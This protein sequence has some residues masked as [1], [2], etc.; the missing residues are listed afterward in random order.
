MK[1]FLRGFL[2]FYIELLTDDKH[3]DMILVSIAGGIGATLGWLPF[4]VTSAMDGMLVSVFVMLLVCWMCRI[5]E[6]NKKLSARSF[7]RRNGDTIATTLITMNEGGGLKKDEDNVLLLESPDGEV[8]KINVD[9][10]EFLVKCEFVWMGDKE[11]FLTQSG[12]ESARMARDTK[13]LALP[14]D[15]TGT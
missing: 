15:K 4:T 10:L 14:A 8:A 9:I 1:D 2:E 3:R 12:M 11:F 13:M 7:V 6:V 5:W